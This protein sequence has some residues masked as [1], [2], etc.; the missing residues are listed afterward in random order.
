MYAKKNSYICMNV[1]VLE[2][3][4]GGYGVDSDNTKEATRINI[5]M[6]VDICQMNK[7]CTEIQNETEERKVAWKLQG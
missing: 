7:S 3:I 2:G 4:G 5:V 6:Y 1:C